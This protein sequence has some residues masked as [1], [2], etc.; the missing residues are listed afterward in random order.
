MEQFTCIFTPCESYKHLSGTCCGL[1]TLLFAGPVSGRE[2]SHTVTC[3]LIR[4][5]VGCAL[6]THG[7]VLV[8]SSHVL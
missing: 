4:E 5:G 7:K 2:R 8:I 6:C 3:V 1:A